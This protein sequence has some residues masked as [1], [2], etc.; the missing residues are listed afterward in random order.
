MPQTRGI[1][2]VTEGGSDMTWADFYTRR[3][4]IDSVLA[5]A[6]RHGATALPFEELDD[7]RSVFADREEL[8]LALQYKWSQALT[9]HV[10][11][12]LSDAERAPDIDHVDAVAAAWRRAAAQQPEVRSLLDA[13]AA[14]GEAGP[15]FRDAQRAEQRMLA[16]AA[17]LAEPG[18]AADEVSRIGAAF[19]ALVRGVPGRT[20]RRKPIEQLLRRLVASA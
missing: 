3:D 7:V 8:G 16:Y 15:R 17:G 9:G 4:A 12:A 20:P 1:T 5:Y 19:I 14:S 10:A 6:R 2:D 13:Y 11:V 18:E